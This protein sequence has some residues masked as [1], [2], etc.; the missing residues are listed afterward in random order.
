[1]TAS[2]RTRPAQGLLIALGLALILGGASPA[3]AAENA[4]N[5]WDF[6]AAQTA[7]AEQAH[8]VPGQLLTAIS[9]VESGRWRADT[10]ENLAW[11]WTVTA[12]GQGRFLPSK[13]AAIAEVKR[14]KAAGINNID[15][16]CMQV[17]LR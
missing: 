6:C 16:G 4:G 12:G 13:A 2:I 14:L 9:K 17:N 11:P 8:G 7:W 15:V 5:P 3:L 1:M 10:Q